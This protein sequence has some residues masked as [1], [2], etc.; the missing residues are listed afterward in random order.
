MDIN[1]SVE[2]FRSLTW[3]MLELLAPSL[4]V[5]FAVA[6]LVGVIQAMTQIQEQTLSFL[7]KLLALF[8]VLYYLAP[9]MMDKLVTLMQT[10]IESIPGMW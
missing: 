7:P 5:G 10:H 3:G 4:I 6:I 2:A 1:S 8:G 9:W